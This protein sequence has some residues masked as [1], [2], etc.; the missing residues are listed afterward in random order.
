M[1]QVEQYIDGATSA[2][3]DSL[4]EAARKR[5]LIVIDTD[6]GPRWMT[7]A[8][9]EGLGQNTGDAEERR[10]REA[11]AIKWKADAKRPAGV[12][13]LFS[14]RLREMIDHVDAL[15][16]EA[17]PASLLIDLAFL[18]EVSNNVGGLAGDLAESLTQKSRA[19]RAA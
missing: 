18:L 4:D 15:G 14:R 7:R 6:D 8:A 17:A 1:E 13:G 11:K 2:G 3:K 10:T 16:D 19:W 9:A 12:L 5:D